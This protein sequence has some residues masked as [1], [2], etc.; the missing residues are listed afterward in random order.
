MSKQKQEKLSATTPEKNRQEKP[1][2]EIKGEL[3]EAQLEA[4]AGG[5]YDLSQFVN[6]N[7]N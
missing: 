7:I 1:V 2:V 6:Q 5:V 3:T 4:I